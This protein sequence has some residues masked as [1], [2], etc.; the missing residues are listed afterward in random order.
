VVI[1]AHIPSSGLER[2]LK[3]GG[4]YEH[5]GGGGGRV[6]RR[7]GGREAALTMCVQHRSCD[8]LRVG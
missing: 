6:E 2:A 3:G 8:V 7:E 5:S 4:K 1:W